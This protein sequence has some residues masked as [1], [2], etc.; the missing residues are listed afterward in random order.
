MSKTYDEIC[1]EQKGKV[2]TMTVEQL[3]AFHRE[4]FFAG[5]ETSLH[6]PNISGS[7]KHHF[8]H[9]EEFEALRKLQGGYAIWS[10]LLKAAEERAEVAMIKFPQPNYVLTKFAEESGEVVKECVHYAESRSQWRFVENEM[11]DALAMM[12]RL[13]VEGDHVHGFVPPYLSAEGKEPDDGQK[14]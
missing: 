2:I 7:C 8:I 14:E 4:A 1:E 10:K 13:L 9:M 12:L 3:Q 6:T 5:H 11:V